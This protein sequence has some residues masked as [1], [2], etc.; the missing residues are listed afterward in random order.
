MESVFIGFRVEKTDHRVEFAQID[1]HNVH[2]FATWVWGN[3]FAD[4]KSF[5]QTTDFHGFFIWL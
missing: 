3:G 4:K 5:Y 1:C 2:N